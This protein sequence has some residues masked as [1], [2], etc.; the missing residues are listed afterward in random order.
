[1]IRKLCMMITNFFLKYQYPIQDSIWVSRRWNRDGTDY[2]D[3]SGWN[4]MKEYYT[5]W[6]GGTEVSD[7]LVNLVKANNIAEY[8]KSI[9]YTDVIIEKIDLSN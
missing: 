2:V 8:Y 4:K 1:M 5:I 6:V 3:L 7:Y 9:G